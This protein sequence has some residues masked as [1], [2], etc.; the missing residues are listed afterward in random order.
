[1]R[2]QENGERERGHAMLY[3]AMFPISSLVPRPS[4]PSVS[5]LAGEGL[6]KLI[7]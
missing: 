6:V 1:M 5:L 7:T 4:H 2:E 3:H